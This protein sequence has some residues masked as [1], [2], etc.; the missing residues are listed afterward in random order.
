M[1]V[2][3]YITLQRRR[4][5]QRARKLTDSQQQTGKWGNQIRQDDTSR[6]GV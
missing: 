3:K 6:F 1:F 5:K 2:G 4:R